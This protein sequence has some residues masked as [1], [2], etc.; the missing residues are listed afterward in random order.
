MLSHNVFESI[1]IIVSI[2]IDNHYCW[3]SITLRK[4][5][6]IL[7]PFAL[8]TPSLFLLKNGKKNF[9]VRARPARTNTLEYEHAQK[10]KIISPVK[11]LSRIVY[12]FTLSWQLHRLLAKILQDVQ[13]S[14]PVSQF[15]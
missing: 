5:T 8:R 11:A 4:K 10:R 13:K 2:F 12:G 15:K 14:I 7:L 9:Y 6:G 3:Y 1:K